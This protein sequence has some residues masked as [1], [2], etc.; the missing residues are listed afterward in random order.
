VPSSFQSYPD[1]VYRV[2]EFEQFEWLEHGFSTRHTGAWP[3]SSRLATAQQI[4]SATVLT[5][6]DGAGQIGT[7]DALISDRAGRLVGVRTADCVP[8]LLVDVRNR[9]VAAIHAGWRGTAQD[10]VLCTISEMAGCFGTT[11]GDLWAAIGPAIRGC[12]YEVG[13]EVARQF[14]R[15]WPEFRDT[16]AAVR[17]DL[18]ETNRRQLVTAGLGEARIIAGR[19]ARFAQQRSFI[20]TGGR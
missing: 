1:H 7:G 6:S 10:I 9:A 13:A 16:N 4:H 8:I 5:A 19:H 17:V 15:W 3:D 11:R 2:A 18:V 12:C 20:P 14:V